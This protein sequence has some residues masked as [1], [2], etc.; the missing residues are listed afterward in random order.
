LELRRA[1]GREKRTE[2]NKRKE[3][4]KRKAKTDDAVL[5]GDRWFC[6]AKRRDTTPTFE[7][8]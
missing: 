6:I 5:D 8:A 1:G 2:D 4:N 3:E 7:D